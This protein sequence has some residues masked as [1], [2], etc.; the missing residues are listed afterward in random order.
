MENRVL[1]EKE[2]KARES[3]AKAIQ[4]D[5]YKYVGIKEFLKADPQL[6]IIALYEIQDVR[7]CADE[8]DALFFSTD[9]DLKKYFGEIIRSVNE[10][11]LQVRA[12]IERLRGLGDNSFSDKW[13]KN[14]IVHK[15]LHY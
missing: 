10:P 15:R 5:L 11:E 1:T 8:W 3:A 13:T 6:L 4:R 2:S 12:L 9:Y 14:R 7:Y